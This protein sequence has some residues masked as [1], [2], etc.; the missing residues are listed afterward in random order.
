MRHGLQL[1]GITLLWL[2]GLKLDLD[3]PVPHCLMGSRDQWEFQQFFRP[4]WQSLCTVLT[5]GNCLPLG[6]CKATVKES[7]SVSIQMFLE[8][9]DIFRGWYKPGRWEN[10]N[11]VRFSKKEQYTYN[12]FACNISRKNPRNWNCGTRHILGETQFKGD[13][14][15]SVLS[16]SSICPSSA[17]SSS[18]LSSYYDQHR[19]CSHHN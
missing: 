6:P 12:Y 8:L 10:N 15:W 2:V 19:R 3:C 17:S 5:A 13:F 14:P 18:T 1:A 9:A 4:Q 7:K 16:L 11:F